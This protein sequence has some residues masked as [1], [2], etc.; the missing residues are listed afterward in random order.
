MAGPDSPRGP[1]PDDWFEEPE[2]WPSHPSPDDWLHPPDEEPRRPRPN[3][4][5]L[6]AGGGLALAALLIGLAAAGVFSGGSPS[7]TPTTSTP[8]TPTTTTAPTTAATPAPTTTLAPGDS[9]A[10]VRALQRA[11]GALGYGPGKIDGAYGPATTSALE[12]FQKAS[13]LT[14]DGILGPKTLAALRRALQGRG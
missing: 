10:Q 1:Q 7:T 13:G 12:R 4:R 14:E 2:Q 5:A 9:G 8:T 11:L 3:R 6:I